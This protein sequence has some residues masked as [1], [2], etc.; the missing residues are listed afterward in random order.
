MKSMKAH[1]K[2][3]KL[4]NVVLLGAFLGVTIPQI[5]SSLGYSQQVP[6]NQITVATEPS[7]INQEEV[8]SENTKIIEMSGAGLL[9]AI[10]VA[11]I[12]IAVIIVVQGCVRIDDNEVGIVIKRFNLNPGHPKLPA[13]RSIAFNGEAGCQADTL[14]LADILATGHGCIRFAKNQ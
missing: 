5:G 7:Q 13:Y 12:V 11:G 14:A 8:T 9:V 1:L 2:I 10:L 6:K 4:A 3:G